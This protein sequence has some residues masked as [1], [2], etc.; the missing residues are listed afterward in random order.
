MWGSMTV[1]I[2]TR[3][4]NPEAWIFFPLQALCLLPSLLDGGYSVLMAYDLYFSYPPL[5]FFC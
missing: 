2:A 4:R 3:Q 1:S 5:H